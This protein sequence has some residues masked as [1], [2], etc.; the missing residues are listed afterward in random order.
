MRR[1]HHAAAL[2]LTLA[3]TL[4]DRDAWP[5]IAED[6]LGLAVEFDAAKQHSE[7]SAQ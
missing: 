6:W 5:L 1:L 4:E 3:Q 7:T 2:Q